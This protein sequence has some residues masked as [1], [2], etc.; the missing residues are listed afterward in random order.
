MIRLGPAGTPHEA[1]SPEEGLEIVH[2]EG[3]DALE[4]EFVRSIYM[5]VPRAEKYGALAKDLGISL[6]IHAPYFINLNSQKAGTI[7]NS[8]NLILRCLEL[9]TAMEAYVV[10]VHAGYYS[11]KDSKGATA[12]TITSCTESMERAEKEGWEPFLGLEL[13]GRV[14]AW[15]TLEEISEVVRTVK[16][17]V[18]VMD[19]SHF[20][21]RYGGA[22]KTEEDFRA[23]IA[24]FEDIFKDFMHAHFSGIKYTDKGEREHITI[25]YKEP[26]YSLLVP[27]LKEKEYD[28]TLISE[29]PTLDKDALVMKRM[30]GI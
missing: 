26:D 21:A 29:S 11:G 10:V 7:E 15:G 5:D 17:V 19:F 18:P 22:L 13:M 23:L 28:I 25:D 12:Q 2:R 30:L 1:K 9:G 20:H 14:S 4:V 6:S 16:G 3:L 24:K 8:K 27:V